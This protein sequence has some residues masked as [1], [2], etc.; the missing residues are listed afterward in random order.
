[1]QAFARRTVSRREGLVAAIPVLVLFIVVVLAGS[2]SAWAAG[3]DCQVQAA[4]V[5]KQLNIP[6]GLLL[7]ISLVESGKGG[8][9][10]PY[11]LSLNSRAVAARSPGEVASRL[12]AAGGGGVVRNA[13]VGCMQISVRHHRTAFGSLD[14]MADPK[15]NVLYA[16]RMLAKFHKD[17]GSWSKAVIRFNGA[18]SHRQAVAYVCKVWNHLSS[19]DT[20]SARTLEQPGCGAMHPPAIS[21]RTRRTYHDAQVALAGPG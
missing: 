17:T 12:R 3:D 8:A 15:A 18:A 13:Y 5:E 4:A 9:P 19:L 16:G 7:A 21:P 20:D 11:A 6:K 10:Q 14:K 2:A 1:M